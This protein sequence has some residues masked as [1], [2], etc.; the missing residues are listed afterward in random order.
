MQIIMD[1]WEELPLVI[2]PYGKAKD[3]YIL[4]DTED[5]V[6]AL[7]DDQM[8]VGTMRGSKHV[9]VIRDL[10]EEWEKRLGYIQDVIDEWLTF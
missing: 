4:A 5:I 8:G 1:R 3:K 9:T 6:A 2:G 7:E 10:V